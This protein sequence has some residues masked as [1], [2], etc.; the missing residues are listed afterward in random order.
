M[1]EDVSKKSSATAPDPGEDGMNRIGAFGAASVAVLMVCLAGD[2]MAQPAA[3]PATGSGALVELEDVIVTARRREERLQDVPISVLAAT[4][5]QLEQRGVRNLTDIANV[6]AGVRLE[7]QQGRPSTLQV[8]I[9]GQ[10]MYG[11][12]LAQDSPTAIYFGDMLM[13]PIVGLNG[14]LYDLASVQVLKGPQGTLFGRN[15]TGGAVVIT[16]QKPTEQLSAEL[17]ANYGNYNSFGVK[18]FVNIPVNDRLFVRISGYHQQ[19]DGY[20]KSITPGHTD[21]RGGGDNVDDFRV[22]VVW[23]PTDSIESYFVAAQTFDKNQTIVPHAYAVN[24]NTTAARFTGATSTLAGANRFPSIYSEIYKPGDD[25]NK[26][27]Q[28]FQ[29]HEQ[30]RAQIFT[31]TTTFETGNITFKNIFGFRKVYS[32]VV[33]TITGNDIPIIDYANFGGDETTSEEFQ[34]SGRSFNDRLNW[35]TG[36]YYVDAYSNSK[37]GAST[38]NPLNSQ[39]AIGPFHMYITSKSIAGY[40]QATYKVTDQLNLTVGGRYTKDIR[41]IT[42]NH[43]YEP[44]L[45]TR[46]LGFP[47]NAP[48]FC[49]LLDDNGV[50]PTVANCVVRRKATFSE[51]TWNISLD[52]HF[53]PQTMVYL[54]QRRG[55]RSGGFHTA[56]T[57][58]ATRLPFRPETVMNYEVGLKADF[59][60]G[61]WRFRLNTAAFYD[62]Y[63]GIQRRVSTLLPNNVISSSVFN[64][65]A[66]NLKGFEVEF[67][68]KPT[69]EL[70]ATAAYTFLKPK[71]TKFDN[72]VN[73]ALRDF[74]DRDLAMVS[75]HQATFNVTWEHQLASD[76]G[77]MVLNANVA[78]VGKAPIDELY[79]SNA[80]LC[81]LYTAAQCA[82]LPADV[83]YY[84]RSYTMTNF[85]ADWKNVMG[86]PVDLGLFV[87][88]AFDVAAMTFVN[89]SYASVGVATVGFA[90]PR[91]VGID[92]TYHFN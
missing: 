5:D 61:D 25:P 23:R 17:G 33:A 71:Y 65:A 9:R 6:A 8:S 37:T 72:F 42:Y 16:P 64:A 88:N 13:V 49:N 31:N 75:R 54:T 79:Q 14:A 4:G 50:R 87:R 82:A 52:Y 77:Q 67:T 7:S 56:V 11:L 27:Y 19:N 28:R 24:P 58:A 80:Q 20:Q 30:L 81:V 29:P 73:G 84:V 15:T 39:A 44:D 62:K 85:R 57:T 10:R 12:A 51:P 68:A 89:P 63:K 36:V 53:S 34:V 86:G 35:V 21:I 2:A 55:Y 40:A 60:A 32:S 83:P 45:L 69:S 43:I 76:A 74:S 26:I 18:G 90:P 92:L 70:T 22:S 91:M 47:D 3:S 48:S 38:F 41:R 1:P 59:N 66:A 46:V 78:Y